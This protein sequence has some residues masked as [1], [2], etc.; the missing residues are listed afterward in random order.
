MCKPQLLLF[1]V[2]AREKLAF[3]MRE[4]NLEMTS[5]EVILDV[6]EEESEDFID[7]CRPVVAA[8]RSIDNL[9]S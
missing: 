3:G 6:I 2:E 8:R 5:S 4:V 7:N 1:A 9:Y